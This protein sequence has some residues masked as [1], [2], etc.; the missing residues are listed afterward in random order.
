MVIPEPTQPS[1]SELSNQST[2]RLGRLPI[3]YGHLPHEAQDDSEMMEQGAS[4][5]SHQLLGRVRLEHQPRE[6]LTGPVVLDR[7]LLGVGTNDTHQGLVRLD[8]PLQLVQKLQEPK[9]KLF[10]GP[11][12]PLL[13]QFDCVEN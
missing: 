10:T 6:R 9:A 1:V 5:R 4:I 2:A 13:E 11:N 8:E 3:Q 7:N 12:G